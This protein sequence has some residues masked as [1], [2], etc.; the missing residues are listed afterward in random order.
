MT[1]LLPPIHT[2]W[3]RAAKWLRRGVIV[4]LASTGVALASR[5][6]VQGEAFRVG[7]VRFVGNE[8][9][10][11]AELRHLSDVRSGAHLWSVDL[12]RAVEGTKRHPWVRQATA[13]RVFPGVVEVAVQE[14]DAALLLALDGLWYVD[15]D[16]V[17]F[18]A[19]TSD[20]LD[21]PVITGISPELAAAQP[22]L[23]AAALWGA[24]RAFHAWRARTDGPPPPGTELSEIHY[25]R[26]LGYE[27]VLERGTRLILGLGDP[28]ERLARLDRV[29]AAGLDLATPQRV[30]LDIGSVAIASPLVPLPVAVPD[31]LATQTGATPL[32]NSPI[33]P[34][35][36]ILSPTSPVAAGQ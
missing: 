7:E 10:A 31:L 28:A 6:V 27:L 4:L 35:S 30:D 13:R 36:P 18:K 16:G 33:S 19:A 9:A 5:E 17:P 32:P 8:R 26:V 20:A 2:L 23:A 25:S 14:H 12:E 21:L 22:E 24:V 29:I 11:T 3:Q 1:D 34:T 15:A